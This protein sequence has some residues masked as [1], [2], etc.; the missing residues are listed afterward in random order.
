MIVI[1]KPM[2]TGQS[3]R[4][5]WCNLNDLTLISEDTYQFKSLPQDALGYGSI[6]YVIESK[7]KN[8]RV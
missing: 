4:I 2:E 3:R 6:V 8:Q 5:V 1:E 7:R